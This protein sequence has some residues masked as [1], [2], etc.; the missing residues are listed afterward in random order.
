MCLSGSAVAIAVAIAVAV[1]VVLGSSD[2]NLAAVVHKLIA[3][4]RCATAVRNHRS[5]VVA[6]WAAI[7]RVARAVANETVGDGAEEVVV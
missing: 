2:S 4:K 1:E 6:H 5:R 3:D 7:A